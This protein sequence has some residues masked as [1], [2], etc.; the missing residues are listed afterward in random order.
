[1]NKERKEGK[2]ASHNEDYQL[3][4]ILKTLEYISIMLKIKYRQA[5]VQSKE[6]NYR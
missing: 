4:F 1:M 6:I 5:K 3:P 2:E